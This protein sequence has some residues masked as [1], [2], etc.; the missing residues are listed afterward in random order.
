MTRNQALYFNPNTIRCKNP[1]GAIPTGSSVVLN[2]Y[3]ILPVESEER[4]NVSIHITADTSLSE[5]KFVAGMKEVVTIKSGRRQTRY[6]AAVDMFNTPGLYFYSFL[7]T[8][9]KGETYTIDN[10][11]QPYQLTVYDKNIKANKD[12]SGAIV[13]QIF[14][15]RFSRSGKVD[16]K[17]CGRIF[18]EPRIYEDWYEN[19]SYEKDGEGNIVKW[20]MY[21]GDLYGVTEKLDYIKSLGANTVYF[22]PVFEAASNH[23]YDTGNYEKID[24]VLGGDEAFD[25]LMQKCREN[26]IGVILD[27][28]FSHTGCNSRY[29]NK[30]N[31]YPDY[32]AYYH[33]DSK[34][35]SWYNFKQF[36]DDVYDCWWGCKD[37]PNVNEL[38]PSYVDYI[39][40]GENSIIKKWMA[41]GI[42]GFRLDVADELPDEFIAKFKK[43]VDEASDNKGIVIGE[44]WED[45][46]NKISYDKRR[47]YF[48]SNELSGVTNYPFRNIMIDFLTGVKSSN[49]VLKNLLCMLDN[50][51]VHNMY[52]SFIMTGSHDVKRLFSVFKE[53]FDGDYQKSVSAHKAY[54]ALMFTFPG[55]PTIYYGDEICMEGEE[56]PDNRRPYPWGREPNLEMLELFKRFG[57]L[58]RNNKVLQNGFIE[59]I[60]SEQDVF[61]Y[62]R[63]Y[64]GGRDVYGDIVEN[65]DEEILCVVNRSFVPVETVIHSLEPN[66]EYVSALDDTISVKTDDDGDLSIAVTD[67]MILERALL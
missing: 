64:S 49:D 8:N 3:S 5:L 11:G 21:G 61:G 43:T 54:G 31:T 59:V 65:P 13:Y 47:R 39:I 9:E 50:Y 22:N 60:S 7:V 20:D 51:P 19:P 67:F 44:V 18:D 6:K 24:P 17:N 63:V 30:Y 45:A 26:G 4:Y 40:T 12:F 57:L 2:L 14:P 36:N 38:D 15:D 27:G 52:S 34:Y 58:R 23:R 48:T 35:R 62:R 10:N 41:K 56:D 42:K 53:A 32:G 33:F 25:E 1:L 29:F 46:S 37:L 55:V 16:I 28:V 66:T